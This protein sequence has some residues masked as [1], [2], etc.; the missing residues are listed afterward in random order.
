[1]RTVII[2]GGITAAHLAHKLLKHHPVTLIMRHPFRIHEL[3]ADPGRLGP[4]NMNSFQ[5]EMDYTMR[6]QAIQS[7]RHRGSIPVHLSQSLKHAVQLGQ[8]TVVTGQ[9]TSAD[10]QIITLEDDGQIPYHKMLL[11][12]GCS[13]NIQQDP[14]I[15]DITHAFSAPT[16]PCGFPVVTKELEWLPGLYVSGPLAELEL[17]PV[18]RKIIGARHA[19]T[20]I[21]NA[22]KNSYS[23]QE[24][25][26]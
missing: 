11:A 21:S 26:I 2:G 14:L 6:R 18:S 22:L 7:A 12:T 13:S 10:H 8:L 24:G 4:K 9:I 20:I 3:D 15:Y 1:M 25:V 5:L 17:G 16:A 23:Y 19:A